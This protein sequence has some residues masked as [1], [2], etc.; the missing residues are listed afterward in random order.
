MN[1]VEHCLEIGKSQLLSQEQMH[2][3]VVH[4]GSRLATYSGFILSL[5]AVMLRLCP[6][7]IVVI[8][9][10]FIT[11]IF[12][13]ISIASI[14]VGT[15]KKWNAGP[16]LD[17]LLDRAKKVKENEVFVELIAESYDQAI[18]FNWD[19]LPQKTDHIKRMAIALS[20]QVVCVA[21]LGLLSAFILM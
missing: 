11:V 8:V 13:Y 14:L 15:P 7:L 10:A 19:V 9:F 6:S 18:E 16:R 4:R 12:I 2:S 21:A 3:D 5:S 1:R 20:V 17:A